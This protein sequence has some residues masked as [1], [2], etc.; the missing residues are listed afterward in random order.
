MIAR[1]VLRTMV[2]EDRL[3]IPRFRTLR[4]DVFTPG[5]QYPD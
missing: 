3:K 1:Q 2:V 4:L 5:G